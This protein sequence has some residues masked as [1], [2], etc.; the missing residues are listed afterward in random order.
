MI[1][2][3][4]ALLLLAGGAAL[5]LRPKGDTPPATAASGASAGSNA[6]G[7]AASSSTTSGVLLGYAIST[8]CTSS[9]GT[10]RCGKGRLIAVVQCPDRRCTLYAS[11]GLFF[12]IQP[13]SV[14]F[15]F[16]LGEP[17]TRSVSI[18]DNTPG[19]PKTTTLKIS[20]APS[21]T[22]YVITASQPFNFGN[23]DGTC[24][25]NAGPGQFRVDVLPYYEGMDI[26]RLSWPA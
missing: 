25:L 15:T 21:G 23:G 10:F 24:D 7:D 19:C 22:G 8:Q 5:A 12:D 16:S 2:G 3:L 4:V 11:S 26:R 20:G 14:P 17:V 13:D 18:P 6:T 1:G 9:T